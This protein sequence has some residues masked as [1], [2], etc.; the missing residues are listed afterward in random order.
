MP[1]T[2]TEA[3]GGRKTYEITFPAGRDKT[4]N[5]LGEAYLKHYALPNSHR[6]A[7]FQ[8]KYQRVLKRLELRLL[9]SLRVY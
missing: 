8:H 9:G 5:M 1:I 6:R 3:F 4:R 7:G 2:L